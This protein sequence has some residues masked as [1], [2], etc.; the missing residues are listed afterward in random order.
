MITGWA[1]LSL[2]YPM[3]LAGGAEPMFISP[4][5]EAYVVYWVVLLSLSIGSGVQ[6]IRDVRVRS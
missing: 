6:T 3:G 5:S 1:V 2:A 4:D